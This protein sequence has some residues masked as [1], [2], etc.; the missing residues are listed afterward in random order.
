MIS[1]FRSVFFSPVSVFL[2]FNSDSYFTLVPECSVRGY[3]P[4]R[5]SVFYLLG[6]VVSEYFPEAFVPSAA[7]AAR[8]NR[9]ASRQPLLPLS[10]RNNQNTK[11]EITETLRENRKDVRNSCFVFGSEHASPKRPFKRF[12]AAKRSERWM[13]PSE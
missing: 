13:R 3:S 7:D 11:K 6:S 8:T 2:L 10:T 9:R 1:L 12:N 5:A 4:P